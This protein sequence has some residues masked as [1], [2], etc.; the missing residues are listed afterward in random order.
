MAEKKIA[1]FFDDLKKDAQQRLIKDELEAIV[2]T[3]VTNI[4]VS[5]DKDL[6]GYDD[7]PKKQTLEQ[8]IIARVHNFNRKNFWLLIWNS[9]DHEFTTVLESK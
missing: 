3:P 9:L 2:E 7:D 4:Q 6:Y 8:R 1:I 5:I